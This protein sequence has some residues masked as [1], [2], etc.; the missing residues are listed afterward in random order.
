M[1]VETSAFKGEA[2]HSNSYNCEGRNQDSG[3]VMPASCLLPSRCISILLNSGQ[4]HL[5]SAHQ[6]EGAPPGGEDTRG[7]R[8][9][10]EGQT[11]PTVSAPSACLSHGACAQPTCW[12]QHQPQVRTTSGTPLPKKPNIPKSKGIVACNQLILK[13]RKQAQRGR[14]LFRGDTDAQRQSQVRS[15]RVLTLV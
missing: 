13:V 4:W 5:L 11:H 12:F 2:N 1:D 10:Q 8:L 3:P 15:P 6:V 7:G 9:K 14:C